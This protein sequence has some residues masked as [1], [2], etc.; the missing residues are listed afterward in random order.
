MKKFP[1]LETDLAGIKAIYSR[2]EL[3]YRAVEMSG[4]EEELDHSHNREKPAKKVGR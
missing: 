4:Q 3:V 1:M 2:G